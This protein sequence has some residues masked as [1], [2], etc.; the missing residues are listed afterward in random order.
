MDN[1]LESF[2]RGQ[3]VDTDENVGVESI[4]RS[5]AEASACAEE[6]VEEKA[7]VDIIRGFRHFL[8]K[9]LRTSVRA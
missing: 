4:Q 2:D 8:R 7:A 6:Y 3:A 1:I 9:L 5:D